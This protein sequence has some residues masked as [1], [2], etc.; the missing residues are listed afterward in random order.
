MKRDRSGCLIFILSVL[1]LPFVI[2]AEL[3]KKTK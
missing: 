2:I 3:L 1:A